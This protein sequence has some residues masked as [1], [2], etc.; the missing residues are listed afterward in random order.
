VDYKLVSSFSLG[1][2]SSEALALRSYGAS[3]RIY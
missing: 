3:V 2:S 1:L